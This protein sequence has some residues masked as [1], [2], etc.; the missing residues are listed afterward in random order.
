MEH[1]SV[2]S[3]GLYRLKYVFCCKLEV[4]DR[5]W[6]EASKEARR[7][8]ISVVKKEARSATDNWAKA[9][10]LGPPGFLLLLKS[11]SVST[12]GFAQIVVWW[13]QFNFCDSS[14]FRGL[15]KT[16]SSR[17]VKRAPE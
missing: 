14:F 10:F 16:E 1:L 3:G 6:A 13:S 15:T 5:D 4:S 11:S 9:K 12:S 8:G 2:P 7:P 17:L